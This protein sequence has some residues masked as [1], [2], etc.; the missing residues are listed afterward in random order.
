MGAKPGFEF[1]RRRVWPPAWDEYVWVG[2]ALPG[3]VGVDVESPVLEPYESGPPRSVVGDFSG[4]LIG[5]N[6]V[7][8]KVIRP[9]KLHN[10]GQARRRCPA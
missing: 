9:I 7:K 2:D 8:A 1:V 4:G 6:E 10:P 5:V 3:V